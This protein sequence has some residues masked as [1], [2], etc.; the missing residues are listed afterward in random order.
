MDQLKAG[1]VAEQLDVIVPYV[2]V[3]EFGVAD[4]AVGRV[5]VPEEAGSAGRQP[6]VTGPEPRLL[7]G[8]FA[9]G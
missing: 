2:R 5:E 7:E 1:V 4:A 8:A 6:V 3:V 9:P